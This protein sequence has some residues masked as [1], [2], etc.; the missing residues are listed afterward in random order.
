MRGDTAVR[1]GAALVLIACVALVASLYDPLSIPVEIEIALPIGLLLGIGAIALWYR[2]E[3][4]AKYK[5][6]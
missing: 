2:A 5:W 3:L 4:I 1:G 6:L